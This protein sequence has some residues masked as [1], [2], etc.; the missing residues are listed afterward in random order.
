MSKKRKY[1]ESY[2]KLGFT[3]KT[4]RDGTQK[5][6]C[7]LCG[8]VLANGSMK[9]AKLSEHL[10]TVHPGNVSDSIDDFRIKRARFE[11][12]GTLP[13]LGFTPTQKP[14]LEASYKVAYRIAQQKKPHTIAETLV[15][16]CALDIVE[17]VCGKDERKK[18][19]AVPLSNDVIHSR[20]VEMSSNVLK[21]VIEELNASP[22]PFSMQLDEST[23]VSQCSQLLVF[24]RYVKHDTR[25]IKEEFLFC[26][27]LLE[28]TKASDVFEMIKIFFIEQ[29]VDWKTKIGSICTDGAPAM[30]GNTSGFA[31]MIKKE[32][33]HVIITHCV[34]HRHALAS[35]TM[36]TFLKEVMS[37]CVKIINFI[38]AR[39]LNH[40][41]FKRLCQEMGSEHEVL[42]YYTEVRW[43]SRGQVLKRLFEL[44]AEVLFFLKDKG[45]S[46]YE[47]LESED[48]V[49][50]LAYLAD[51]FNHLNEINLSLQGPAVTIV[52]ASERLKGFLGKLPLWKRRVESNHFANFPMLEELI[53]EENSNTISKMVQNEVSKHLETLQT[54]FEGY[55]S[56]ESLEKETWV[57]SPFLIDIDNISDE[58]LIKDDLIDMRSKE[59]LKAEFHAKDLGEFWC[60]LSQAYPLLVKRAMSVLIPFATTYLCEAGFSALVSIKTKSRNRLNVADDMRLALSKTIPQFNILIEAKQQHPSH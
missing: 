4:E 26:D 45:N 30:L 43:L 51:I 24:V 14:C 15:K 55:F 2:V 23:D 41:L 8:K 11:K 6:Q 10:K 52:D 38:R 46:L 56:S 35:R 36:P 12:A 5:P 16:P 29:N 20:I 32:I 1:D 17:L 18:V 13:K 28:T 59:L 47:Y 34:L 31:A 58:D 19:E 49:Q 42:L 7:F 25:S 48:F 40:R 57:R 50:G 37:T 3:F 33:P 27:S 44:R 39:A 9:P 53:R 54:S 60:S 22:F 21:Q